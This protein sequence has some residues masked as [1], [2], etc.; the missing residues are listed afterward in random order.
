MSTTLDDLRARELWHIAETIRRQAT[1]LVLMSL[2]ATNLLALVPHGEFQGGLEFTARVLPFNKNGE[3]SA[4]PRKMRVWVKLTWADLYD[5]EVSYIGRDRQPVV[6]AQV[7]NIDFTQLPV[8]LL[9]LDF[10]GE[11]VLNPRIW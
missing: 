5:V 6:H 9:A 8:W 1:P 11:T 7:E 3:R 10:D 2:G 4:R